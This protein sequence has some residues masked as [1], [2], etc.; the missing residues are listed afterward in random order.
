MSKLVAIQTAQISTTLSMAIIE[1][2]VG[3]LYSFLR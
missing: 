1:A 2:P 3:D